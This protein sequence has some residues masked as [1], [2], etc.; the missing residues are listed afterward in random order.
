MDHIK[1][2]ENSILTND[3]SLISVPEYYKVLEIIKQLGDMQI[4]PRL[5]RNCVSSSQIVQSMLKQNGIESEIVEC[6]ALIRYKKES[7][8]DQIFFIGYDNLNYPGQLDTHLVVITKTQIPIFID[9]S[10]SHILPEKTPFIAETMT[11]EKTTMKKILQIENEE[12]C[13][14]YQNKK[15]I[16]LP[17]LHQKTILDKISEE[18]SFKK[19]VKTIKILVI[20]ASVLGVVNFLANSF[21]IFGKTTGLF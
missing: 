16:R 21:L 9:L 15:I 13:I 20:V 3:K 12:V 5:S 17:E 1:I 14:E 2:V 18:R 7:S 11:S 8:S 10:L 19:I 6:Q 4:L